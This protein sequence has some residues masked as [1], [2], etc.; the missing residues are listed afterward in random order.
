MGL[1]RGSGAVWREGELGRCLRL[2]RGEEERGIRDVKARE[3]KRGE[4]SLVRVEL[5]NF[6]SDF[7]DGGF[8]SN[9]E[10]LFHIMFEG[11]L[12]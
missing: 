10:L 11:V 5:F 1:G 12:N 2:G 6:A 3:G 8:G 9:A 7:L 4:T